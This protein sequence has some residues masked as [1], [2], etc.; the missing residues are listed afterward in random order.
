[1]IAKF[2]G[3]TFLSMCVLHPG[4]LWAHHSFSAEFDENKPVKLTGTVTSVR[5]SNP[6]AWVYIDVKDSAGKVVNW[7][8]ELSAANQLYRRG[9]RREDLA[10]GAMVTIDG[11]LARNGTPT[12]NTGKI[13]L[14]DGRQMFSGSPTE[15]ARR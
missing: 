10:V 15:G 9:W 7:A 13:V 5:W 8:F 3:A 12:A 14:P 2:F 6:H 1:M 11:W 4:T